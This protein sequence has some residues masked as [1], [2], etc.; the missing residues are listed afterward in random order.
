MRSRLALAFITVGLAVALSGCSDPTEDSRGVIIRNDLPHSVV[1]KFCDSFGCDNLSD[2]IDPGEENPE[3]VSV[4]FNPYAFLVV[5][6]SGRAI[7]CLEV[8][9]DPMP[10]APVVISTL[11]RDLDAPCR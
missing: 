1:L 11:N 5:D 10:T 4:E 7:G 6:P 8:P 9:T 3:N 2:R